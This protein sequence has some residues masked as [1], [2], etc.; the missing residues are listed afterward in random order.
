[1]KENTNYLMNNYKTL[2]LQE[3]ILNNYS[4]ESRNFSPFVAILKYLFFKNLLK[5]D[6]VPSYS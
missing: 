3:S 4:K 5:Y 1:M 2:R 6:D